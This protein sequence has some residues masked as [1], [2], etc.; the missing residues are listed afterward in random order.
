M[1]KASKSKEVIHF[2][3]LYGTPHPYMNPLKT[4]T[5]AQK[6]WL[7]LS[8]NITMPFLQEMCDILQEL[9]PPFSD[10]DFAGSFCKITAF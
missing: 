10:D 3:P 4:N 1:L 5:Q 2:T 9:L 7:S 6:Q 8:S